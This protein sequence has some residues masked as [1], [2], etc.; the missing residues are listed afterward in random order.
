M[1]RR[2]VHAGQTLM[3]MEWFTS[4]HHFKRRNTLRDYCNLGTRKHLAWVAPVHPQHWC[5]EGIGP[6]FP[7]IAIMVY[8]ENSISM[9]TQSVA[10][11]CFLTTST[12]L[13]WCDCRSNPVTSR[14][15]TR[16][17]SHRWDTLV[18]M[19]KEAVS[20]EQK[21]IESAGTLLAGYMTERTEMQNSEPWSMKMKARKG[22]VPAS[23]SSWS[24]GRNGHEEIVAKQ[25]CGS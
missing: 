4:Q 8:H 14:N 16:P 22:T 6:K 24:K 20:Y 15:L 18:G 2:D 5:I 21:R 23:N 7:N 17:Q 19:Q 13:F 12:L 11:G 1:A 9:V 10:G 25:H 3:V